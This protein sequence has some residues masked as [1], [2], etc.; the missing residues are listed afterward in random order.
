M[1]EAGVCGFDGI[2]IDLELIKERYA[3]DFIQ[4]IRELCARAHGKGLIVSVNNYVPTYTGY[5][6]RSA[7]IGA[8]DYIVVMAYDEHTASSS[9][10]GSA[11]SY[12]FVKQGVED[13]IAE[14]PAERIILGVPFYSRAW[15]EVF[16]E[17][18]FSTQALDMEG[19]EN[20][21]KEHDIDV[22]LYWS[23][24]DG[25]YFGTSTDSDAR[26]SI[27][28]EEER[29]L[30]LKLGLVREYALAGAAAWRLGYEKDTIWTTW[31][32]CLGK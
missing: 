7:Q 22:Y 27:W 2:N 14:V 1:E 20:F 25:Q 11:A 5:Y 9:E 15:T 24:P 10:I 12:P 18:G 29:S 21:I 16:G 30:A 8:C 13:T 28:Q 23:E 26:Y 4:F 19:A 17:Q 6:N 32:D 3:P 31:T